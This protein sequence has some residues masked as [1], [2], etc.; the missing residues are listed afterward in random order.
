MFD[1]DLTL[2]DTCVNINNEY[3][4]QYELDEREESNNVDY[5]Q[6]EEE[7]EDKKT[8][9]VLS[10]SKFFTEQDMVPTSVPMVNVALS[11]KY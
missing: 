2:I 8:T 7:L 9:E 10:N 3:R 1:N 6:T 11:W 5:G 4:K